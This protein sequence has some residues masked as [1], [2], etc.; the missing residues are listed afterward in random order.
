MKPY[1]L[2]RG[3]FPFVDGS[4]SCSSH[5]VVADG[6]FFQVNNSFLYWKQHDQLI[7]SVLLFSLSINALHPVI[8]C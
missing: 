3:V 5:V 8:S 1:L 6:S 4:L 7:L 2:G